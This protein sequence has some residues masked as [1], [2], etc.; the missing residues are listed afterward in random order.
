[1]QVDDYARCIRYSGLTMRGL[2]VTESPQW[3]K[4]RL[5]AIG[6]RPINSVV[7]VTNYILFGLG[8][9]LHCFDLSKVKGGR[10]EVR[11]VADGTPS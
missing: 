11:T 10:I 6:Q 8:Q 9:P 4:D 5:T 2:K 7:D 3:L 1:M